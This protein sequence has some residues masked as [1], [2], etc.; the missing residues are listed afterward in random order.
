MADTFL[1]SGR[2]SSAFSTYVADTDGWNSAARRM[3]AIN[4]PGRSGTLTPINSNSFENIQITYLCYLKN[5]MRTKLNDL[6]GWLNSHA[7]YQRLEDTFHP[8]YFRLARYNG[9]FEVMSKDKLTAAF[10]VVFDCMP[11]KFLKSGEQITT[12]KT[13]GSITNPTNYIAKPIIKIYGTGVVKIG[14][15]AIKIVKPG[16]AFIEFDCD[17]L[18]AYEGSDNRNSNVELIGEPALLPNT[19]NGITLGNGITKVEIKPRWYTI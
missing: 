18:N 12:L 4:V 17:L 19:T 16:N 9:S 2:K 3:D 13:S 8:E 5:E 11:Q 7:G 10:N 14:S 6:V 15:A 1:F